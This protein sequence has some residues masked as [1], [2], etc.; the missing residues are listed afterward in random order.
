MRPVLLIAL[1]LI[2]LAG[3]GLDL[4]E[5]GPLPADNP[6][7]PL[8]LAEDPPVPQP[9]PEDPDRREA[10][11]TEPK[12][13][14]PEKTDDAPPAKPDKSAAQPPALPT[15]TAPKPDE[16]ALAACE[17]EL[18]KLGATFKRLEPVAGDNG[19]AI[20]APYRIDTIARGVTL[21]P[22]SQLRCEAALALARW[23]AETVVPA[24]GALPGDVTLTRINHGSTYVCRRR[25]NAS[26]GKMSEHAIGNAIDIV[27]FDFEGRK[28]IGITPRAGDG[29]IE[30]AFQRAVRGGACLYFT[31]VLGPGTNKAHADHLHFDIAARRGGYRLCE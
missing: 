3:M 30:E 27:D 10:D 13:A 1:P 11:G 31:T 19:C 23:T 5:K 12:A 24:V 20:A 15:I 28:P 29:N 4:P 16:A 21:A 9:R 17:A 7:D 8:A 25:N 2:L 14:A 22:A 18:R 6:R 26:T